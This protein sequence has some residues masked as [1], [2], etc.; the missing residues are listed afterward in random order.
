MLIEI[1]ITPE[2]ESKRCY[3]I[4]MNKILL[5][6]EYTRDTSLIIQQLFPEMAEIELTKIG[7][8]NPHGIT[9]LH[10]MTSGVT[11]VWTNEAFYPWLM[12]KLLDENVKGE[13][14]FDRQTSQFVESKKSLETLWQGGSVKSA[15]EFLDALDLIRE[16]IFGFSVMFYS[17][18]DERT[19]ENIKEKTL[20]LRK[21]DD[22]WDQND[23]FIRNSIRSLYPEIEGYEVTLLKQEINSPPPLSELQKRLEG[24]TIGGTHFAELGSLDEF[25][26]GH[27][28]YEFIFE[29]S[30]IKVS[31]TSMVTGNVANKGYAKGIARI[32][33]RVDDIPKVQIGDI[34][35][36]PMTTPNYIT[37]MGKAVAF[38][39]DEGGVL[40]HAAIVSREMNKPCIVGTGN[41]TQV[42]KD[43]DIIELDTEKGIVRRL[44]S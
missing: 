28:E 31:N 29:K 40:C 43:G 44:D 30:N 13:G 11:Q 36:S 18:L 42:F 22:F 34:I 1:I 33:M 38:V 4:L 32:L 21:E 39:T 6:K 7:W 15:Y 37:A 24:F 8:M 10:H 2:L 5:H 20:I 9:S 19:P 25:T 16:T 35:V 23:T 3:N 27:P 14:F 41:A 12:Q 17:G 26:A